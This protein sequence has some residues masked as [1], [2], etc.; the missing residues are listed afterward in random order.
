M[1]MLKILLPLLTVPLTVYTQN[2]TTVQPIFEPPIDA[3]KTIFAN[4][5]TTTST[6][7]CDGCLLE[8]STFRATTGGSTVGSPALSSLHPQYH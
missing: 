7:T 5:T 3:T 6:V 1:A 4:T 2:C 8:V